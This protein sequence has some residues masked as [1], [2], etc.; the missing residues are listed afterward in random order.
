[1]S[2]SWQTSK[3]ILRLDEGPL[4]MGILNVTPD[5]FSD[6]GEYFSVEASLLRAAKMIADGAD[7]IDV[8][9]ES[10]RP[11]SSRVDAS[12]EIRRTAPVIKAIA[13][14]FSIPVSIDTSRSETAAAAIDAGAEII[15][16]V[17]G[18]R[19][20]ARIAALASETG[21]GLILMHS[22]GS[23]ESMHSQEPVPDILAEVISGFRRSILIAKEHGVH[24]DQIVLD[25]GL[26][27]GKTLEQNL[28]LIAKLDKIVHELSAYPQLVGASRKSFIGK[29]L[30]GAGPEERLGG[31][32]CAAIEAVNRGAAIIRVHDVKQ[33]VDALSML[34]ALR[35]VE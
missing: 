35:A 22:R 32:L 18:L 11:G 2:V 5:S 8:G 21:C 1:M 13:E 16:D 31:S 10:T 26:G 7:I 27:F 19:F 14:R 3:R 17:S 25:I 4:V 30:N 28:E 15:N 23:F 6:G 9:G 33:S 29:V 20:D 12:E 24:D 34:N